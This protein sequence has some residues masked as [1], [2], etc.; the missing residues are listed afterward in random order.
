MLIEINSGR[1]PKECERACY[2]YY[3]TLINEFPSLKVISIYG[4]EDRC[5]KSIILY[6]EDDVSHLEGTVQWICQS[7]FRPHH[8]RK[9]W[10]IDVSILKEEFKFDKREDIQF[11]VFRS[12]GKGGQNVNKVSTAIRAIH[13]PTG[14]SVICEDQRSQIQNKKSAYFRLMKKLD[15]TCSSI[16]HAI[17]YKN[18][19]EKNQLVRG[20]PNRIYKGEKFKRSK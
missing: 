3:K 15:E 7:P 16:N 14:L 9:N 1:G 2:L 6:T 8:K 18:W 12:S 13:I 20:Q 11:E 19:N 17:E 10:F 5:V 4:E